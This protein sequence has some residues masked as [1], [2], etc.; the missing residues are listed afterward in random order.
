MSYEKE[1]NRAFCERN[2]WKFTEALEVF[3]VSP[4]SYPEKKNETNFEIILR[5]SKS[6]SFIEKCIEFGANF[7]VVSLILL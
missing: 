5:T 3:E 2:V 7:N 1:L 6:S 4:N